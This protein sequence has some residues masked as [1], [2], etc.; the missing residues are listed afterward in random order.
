MGQLHL[1]RLDPAHGYAGTVF[2]D[3]AKQRPLSWEYCR[4]ENSKTCTDA[5]AVVP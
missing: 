4:G 2:G 3:N 5:V 1:E